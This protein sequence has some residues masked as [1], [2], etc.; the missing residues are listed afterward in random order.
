MVN[1]FGQDG[2]NEQT[3]FRHTIS[4]KLSA[5]YVFLHLAVYTPDKIRPTLCNFTIHR[6]VILFFVSFF[7]IRACKLMCYHDYS[8]SVTLFCINKFMNK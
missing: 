6:K 5:V 3:S 7:L 2:E 1:T 8:F 4:S